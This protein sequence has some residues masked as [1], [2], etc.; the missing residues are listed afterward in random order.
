MRRFLRHFVPFAAIQI[1]I[2][3][4]VLRAYQPSP[5]HIMA[6][7]IDKHR[8]LDTTPA[9]RLVLVG[10]SSVLFGIVS[11][12][13]AARLPYH[14]INTS[15]T[16][17]LGAGF[18][19]NDVRGSLRPGDVAVVSIEYEQF[20]ITGT[21]EVVLRLL[22][23]RPASVAYVPLDYWPALLDYGVSYG[24]ILVRGAVDGARGRP[25]PLALPNVRDALDRFGDDSLRTP[26]DKVPPVELVVFSGGRLP[27]RFGA[28]MGELDR[29][30][31][32]MRARGVRVYFMHPPVP[33]TRWRLHRDEIA[34]AESVFV[35]R[36]RMPML[37]TPEQLVFPD[38]SFYDTEYH[39]T[40]AGAE[41][42]TDLLVRSLAAR[43]AVDTLTAAR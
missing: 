29:F 40:R 28:V 39:L 41:R 9:P 12:T 21:P 17:G 27:R 4:L 35:R 33:A 1:V 23:A 30:A 36:L 25:E 10:G 18:I 32:D 14:P 43:L 42:R 8:L 2:A 15:I 31:D 5:R 22:A 6:S 26:V 24:G 3:L 7:T 37:D 13:L 38:S 16:A 11:D 19:L 20:G 34:L